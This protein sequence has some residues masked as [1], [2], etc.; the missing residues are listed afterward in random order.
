MSEVEAIKG[1]LVD[2]IW[3]RVDKVRTEDGDV[4]GLISDGKQL[5]AWF[6]NLSSEEKECFLMECGS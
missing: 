3:G 6:A 5:T 2:V 4:G 1:W